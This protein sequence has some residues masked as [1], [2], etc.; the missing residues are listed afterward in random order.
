[1]LTDPHPSKHH[2]G[3]KHAAFELQQE[4]TRAEAK[5]KHTLPEKSEVDGGAN[6]Y[7]H[8]LVSSTVA[9][10]GRKYIS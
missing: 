8:I 2:A 3:L 6:W 7:Q 4:V 10:F 5:F 9:L 1:M